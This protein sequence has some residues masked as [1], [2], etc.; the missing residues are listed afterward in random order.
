MRN[1]MLALTLTAAAWTNAYAQSPAPTRYTLVEVGGKALPTTIEKELRCR[2]DVTAGTLSL[3][4][5]GRWLLETVTKEI[6]G[7]R[8]EEDSDRDHGTYAAEGQ[9]FRFLDEDG[10][11]SHDSGWGVG[12][13]DD[14]DEFRTGNIAADGS[15]T[16][17]LTDGTPLLFRKA[18]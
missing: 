1:L 10:R 17:K 18:S 9:T 7:D 5:D 6:C 16:I 15:L 2:E 12:T 8:T 13:D 11:E 4:Q 3:S 14:L